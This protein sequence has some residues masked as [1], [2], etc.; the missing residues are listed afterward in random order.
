MGVICPDVLPISSPAEETG[1]LI[2]DRIIAISE[3]SQY[4]FTMRVTIIKL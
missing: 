1:Y 2:A 3:Y 4:E